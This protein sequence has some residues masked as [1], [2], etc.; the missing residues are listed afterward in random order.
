M[1]STRCAQEGLSPA[2]LAHAVR[3][4]CELEIRALKPGNVGLHGDGHG[5][6]AADFLASAQAI[7][8]P[9]CEPGLGVG[10]RILAAVR[11]TRAVATCNTNLGIVLL[12]AP[13]VAA[14][15]RAGAQ[16]PLRSTLR[17]MLMELDV[18]DAEH[19]YEAIRLAR[20]GGLG[21]VARHD[22]AET[23]RVSLLG[24]MREAG[25]RDSIA[26][27]YVTAYADVFE[28]GLPDY[29][30]RLAR[31]GSAEWAAVGVFLGFLS[32]LPDSHISRKHGSRVARTVSEEARRACTM[33]DAAE[34][35]RQRAREL[36]E[37]D[38]RLKRQGINPGTSADLTVATLLAASIED[39]LKDNNLPPSGRVPAWQVTRGTAHN[40]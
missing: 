28:H 3:D 30:A 20:A 34:H 13:L 12:C 15:L 14:A 36:R 26:R 1:L 23:P 37:W 8:M 27:Q 31:W 10:Q 40:L 39:S 33:L 18:E 25:R 7:A 6:K 19:A 24:A 32:Y 35:P 17:I 2:A 5:M 21:T 4:A 29:R 38:Q 11:A 22:I 9:L 16:Q